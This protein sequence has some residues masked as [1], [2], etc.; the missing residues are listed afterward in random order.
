MID[1]L[2]RVLVVTKLDRP[3]DLVAL[4]IHDDIRIMVKYLC[5]YGSTS[6][7]TRILCNSCTCS[8]LLLRNVS[9]SV[10]L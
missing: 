9:F 8:T 2:V 3:V 6:E 4:V 5:I 10:Y 1:G 7:D